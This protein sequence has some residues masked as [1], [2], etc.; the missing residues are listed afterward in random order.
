MVGDEE[1][2]AASVMPSL[3]A[4]PG[5]RGET[6][7]GGGGWGGR[8]G[9][10]EQGRT[11]RAASDT[12]SSLLQRI[13]TEAFA[14]LSL[15]STSLKA[16]CLSSSMLK[17]IVSLCLLKLSA[18]FDISCVLLRLNVVLLLEHNL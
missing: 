9:G 14:I 18:L 13:P 4:D 16:S 2:S 3:A 15:L 7:G 12:A 1:S 6:R 10:E 8:G 17:H 5:S 11:G